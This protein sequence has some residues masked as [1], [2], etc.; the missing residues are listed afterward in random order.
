MRKLSL[1][2]SLFCFVAV[3]CS[4]HAAGF[5]GGTGEAVKG[6]GSRDFEGAKTAG[7]PMII[8]IYDPSNNNN[9]VANNIE[10]KVVASA[11]VKEKMRGFLT[12]KI[13]TDGTDVKGWPAEILSRAGKG[14]AVGVISSD[15]AQMLFLD[16]TTGRE[17]MTSQALLMNILSI[18]NYEEKKKLMADKNGGGK[19]EEK[20][21][22]PEKQE[23]KKT[24]PGLALGDEKDKKDAKKAPE[25]KKVAAPADE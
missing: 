18:Q 8:Y 13:K 20:G 17:G 9:S 1:I 7:L 12:I 24:V 14:A 23:E 21:L 16:K 3:S 5:K 11:E 19:K 4:L 10:T 6:W 22:M 2:V 15:F 25:K